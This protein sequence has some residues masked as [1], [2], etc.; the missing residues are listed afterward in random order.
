MEKACALWEDVKADQI[1]LP[2]NVACSLLRAALTDNK[3]DTYVE[4]Y[5]AIPLLFVRCAVC[6]VEHNV[7][8][9]GDTGRS[10]SQR[11]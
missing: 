3:I 5:S 6:C 7:L 11:R 2:W 4:R 10:V 1:R 9:W 8:R